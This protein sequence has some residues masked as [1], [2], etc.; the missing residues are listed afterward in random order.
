[1]GLRKSPIFQ[2]AIVITV[3]F[4]LSFLAAKADMIGYF[5][6]MAAKPAPAPA[7]VI[8]APVPEPAPTV[9]VGEPAPATEYFSRVRFP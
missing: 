6:K 2:L 5:K 9:A 3:I 8:L 7:P 1:M 4:L